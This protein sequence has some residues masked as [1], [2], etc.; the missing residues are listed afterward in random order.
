[1]FFSIVKEGMGL[2]YSK[3]DAGKTFRIKHFVKNK[4][5]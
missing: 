4:E 5:A 1:M 3:E 2:N